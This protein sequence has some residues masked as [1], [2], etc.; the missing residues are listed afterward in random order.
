M[1]YG[2]AFKLDLSQS[3]KDLQRVSERISLKQND[4][5]VDFGYS[6]SP[7]DDLNKFLKFKVKE[8][9]DFSNCLYRFERRG[10]TNRDSSSR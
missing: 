2:L 4:K 1:K 7:I 8:E 5:K 6:P 9:F 3:D 10:K